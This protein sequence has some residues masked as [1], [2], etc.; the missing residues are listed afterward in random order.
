MRKADLM[1]NILYFYKQNYFKLNNKKM[2]IMKNETN[3]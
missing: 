2:L 1:Q 3:K